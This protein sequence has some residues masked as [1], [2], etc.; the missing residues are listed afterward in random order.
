MAVKAGV[1]ALVLPRLPV[2]DVLS[3]GSRHACLCPCAASSPPPLPFFA[4]APQAPALRRCCLSACLL[5]Y[6]TR[7]S[8]RRCWAWTCCAR[9]A[10][11]AA[12]AAALLPSPCCPPPHAAPLPVLRRPS[13]AWARRPCSSSRRSTSSSSPTTSRRSS[14]ATHASSRTR[15]ARDVLE[16]GRGARAPLSSRTR[17]TLCLDLERLCWHPRAPCLRR[18]QIG[19]EF[20]RFAKFLPGVKCAVLFGGLPRAQV[21][22]MMLGG[23]GGGPAP[24]RP[25]G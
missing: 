6:N 15:C 7:P 4:T 13:P 12:A 5:Q 1:P 18:P 25:P 24:G 17:C 9:C 20:N 22:R 23:G 8:R 11:N 2:P 14:C 21:R 19:N 3:S 16:R 10:H